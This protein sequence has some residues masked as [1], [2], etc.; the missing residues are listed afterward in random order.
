MSLLLTIPIRER[1]SFCHT[2]EAKRQQ[3]RRVLPPRREAAKKRE[4][5]VRAIGLVDRGEPQGSPRSGKGITRTGWF[6]ESA[7]RV[8]ES[9]PSR[10]S[11]GSG[12]PWNSWLAPR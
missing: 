8:S 1:P 4:V 5:G 10:T 11:R 3:N 12:P 2:R 7:Q 6:R 9:I